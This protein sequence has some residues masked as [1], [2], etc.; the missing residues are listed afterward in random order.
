MSQISP[1]RLNQH[2]LLGYSEFL[3]YSKLWIKHHNKN[4]G[5]QKKHIQLHAC[6]NME[7]AIKNS[8]EMSELPVVKL[9]TCFTYCTISTYGHSLLAQKWAHPGVGT[10]VLELCKW[11]N[12]DAPTTQKQALIAIPTAYWLYLIVWWL[13]WLSYLLTATFFY[14]VSELAPTCWSTTQNS[15]LGLLD[16]NYP[17]PIY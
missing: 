11:A 17:F 7:A 4:L 5:I 1:T 9:H 6:R 8:S 15:S 13:L 12:L 14:I 2:S 16:P 10:R 3:N